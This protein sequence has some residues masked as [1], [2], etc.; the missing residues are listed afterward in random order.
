MTAFIRLASVLSILGVASHAYGQEFDHVGSLRSLASLTFPEQSIE[1]GPASQP[2]MGVYKPAGRGPFA[3]VVI[4]HTCGGVQEHIGDWTKQLLQAGYAVLVLDSLTQR[5]LQSICK[6][7]LAVRTIEGTLDAYRALEHLA[8]QPYI[9]KERI[10]L[11]GFSWGAMSALLASREDIARRLPRERKELKFRAV[12]AAYPHCF[13]P[14]V[15]TPRGPVAVDYLGPDTDRPL[16]ILMGEN[17]E[18]SPA[19]FCLPRLEALKAKGAN[20]EWHVLANAT[21]AWDNK[22][23]DGYRAPNLFFGGS[24][25]IR[26]S[27]EATQA[28]Q[29]QLLDFLQRE[30]RSGKRQ[31]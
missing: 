6:P 29:K 24:H 30:M 20:V 4:H 3:A 8:A 19:K 31:D 27:S 15:P 28:S 11:L 10:A 9:D 5:N 26:Y 7:P 23:A 2:A 1:S 25:T 18:E 14:A 17:D 12:A 22:R 21:H 13:I 16:L